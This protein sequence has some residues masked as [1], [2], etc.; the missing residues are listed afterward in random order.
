MNK[1]LK[2]CLTEIDGESYDV[3][4]IL[5]IAGVVCF[6]GLACFH[7]IFLRHDFDAIGYGTGLGGLLGGGG[8]GIGLRGKMEGGSAG[9]S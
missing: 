6:L 1:F 4:R 5:F 8:A 2:D 9:N 3:A 7:V